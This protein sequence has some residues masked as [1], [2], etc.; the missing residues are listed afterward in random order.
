M[1]DPFTLTALTV[2]IV[3]NAPNWLHALDDTIFDKS[4]EVAINKG[5]ELIV[6]RGQSSLRRLF[7]L[8]EKEQLRH[9]EQAL[10][11]ATERGIVKFTTL[12][13]R[14]QYRDILAT[15]TQEGPHNEVILQEALR[16]F[17]LSDTPNFVTLNEKYNLHK[18]ITAAA[19][20]TT[21]QEVDVSAYLTSFFDA[22]IAELYADSYFKQQISN[23][24]QLRAFGNMQHS[25]LE[26]VNT[27]RQIG[28]ALT[29]N[30]SADQF[31]RDVEKY[32]AHIE[33]TFHYLKIIGVVFREENKDPELEGIFVPLRVD[34]QIEETHETKSGSAIT[35]RKKPPTSLIETLEQYS[36][37]VLLGGP[38]SGKSTA[39]RHLAWSHAVAHQSTPSASNLS[40]L[41]GSPLPLRIELRRLA[42][43]RKQSNYSFLSYATEVLLKREGVDINLQMFKELL[44]RRAML[45]L[46]DGLD[47]VATLDERQGLVEEIVHFA[48][49][50]PG[51]RII[52]TSRPVGYELTG[53]SHPLFVHAQV[54][55]FN[56]KQ[57]RRFLVYWYSHVLGFS[58]LPYEEQQELETLYNTL[59]Q[60]SRL[61]KL[62]EN[63][64]LLT[65]ITALYRFERL[66][67]RRI[68]L[69]DRCADLLLEKWAKLRGTDS[70]WKE[71]KMGKEDQYACVAHLGFVLHE[72]SQ[73]SGNNETGSK[74]NA[75]S[76]VSTKFMLREIER[77]IKSGQLITEVAQQR[78]EAERFLDLMQVESGLIVERGTEEGGGALYGFV[79]RTFQ[80]Y[81]AAADVYERFQNETDQMI[82]SNFLSEHLHD[83][84]WQEVILLLL[85]KLRR[86]SIVTNQLRPILQGIVKSQRSSY[87]GI[88]EQDLFFV[89]NCLIDEIEVDNE[90]AEL[91]ISRLGNVVKKTPFPSQRATAL[92]YFVRLKKT[93][94]YADQAT[95][96]LLMLA[97]EDSI[98]NV[99]IRLEIAKAL[100][101]SGSS[102]SKERR[103][104]LQV[105]LELAQKLDISFENAVNSARTLYKI[106]PEKSEERRLSARLLLQLAQ[107]N[108]ISVEQTLLA[109]QVL[110]PTI[111]PKRER[112]PEEQ[113]AEQ[114]LRDFALQAHL[115]V[116][117]VLQVAKAIEGWSLTSD[118]K[119][120]VVQRLLQFTQD[121]ALLVEEKIQVA[122]ALYLLSYGD[123]EGQQA[124]Q[125]LLDFIQQC[126]LSA[127]QTIQ[128]AQAVHTAYSR[129]TKE[130]QQA[131]E[132]LLH[133]AQ[134][135]DLPIEQALKVAEFLYHRNI[136]EE[137]KRHQA[138]QLLLSLAQRPNLSTEQT[139][140]V[141]KGLYTHSYWEPEQKQLAIQ[142]L[143]NL[144]LDESVA[145]V[146]RL[147]AIIFLAE[148]KI[149]TNYTED[150]V[151]LFLPKFIRYIIRQI[152]KEASSDINVSDT[153]YFVELTQQKILSIEDR[154]KFYETLCQMVPQ[155]H[156]LSM[157][158][159]LE[160]GN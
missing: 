13:E 71:M 92:D 151:T 46:F 156:K 33:R 132:L 144:A 57:I 146:Q 19:Q 157:M 56:N 34:P 98:E 124:K 150:E 105:F 141:M 35:V 147:S 27:L 48:L 107:R 103:Q 137:E 99:S 140:Q 8:D 126:D 40:L 76:D 25:L 118:E 113:Q 112:L 139:L 119:Q 138:A 16:L 142:K 84:H 77:F 70:R 43:E 83:P 51:N 22:L 102:E 55:D 6:E 143:M 72:R 117:Q 24:L 129:E 37:L 79:H 133:L 121:P 50:H 69:Y 31:S 42:E 94:K 127:E 87:T 49:S 120:P 44:E 59:R 60:N 122:E 1:V 101:Q 52:V 11:N 5:Q 32:A 62:A 41:S 155:F 125:L 82:V 68:L 28:E 4:K 9:L 18:R 53:I 108:N 134:A 38:G 21:Y 3:K 110:K 74:G 15:L 36:C 145:I 14:D 149:D 12:A 135:P 100:F 106:S 97:I 104:A 58:P 116:K 154:N 115:T 159:T 90:L 109:Y 61:H 114:L 65:V 158:H 20:Q 73:E 67:D 86:K 54:Q 75:A 26:V 7:H 30:Y 130:E 63:P 95:E 29:N 152:A 136:E 153:P 78:K 160:E 45:L 111:F 10:K 81:F 88:L 91:V 64:L 148:A 128:A 89:C 123:A 17:S 85:S 39:L 80:E 66:P 23:V 47:E 93:R 131:E 2:L 96:A